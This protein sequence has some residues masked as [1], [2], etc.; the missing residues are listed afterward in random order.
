MNPSTEGFTSFKELDRRWA[1]IKGSAFRAFKR[2][3]PGLQEGRDFLRLDA[4]ADRDAIQRLRRAGRIYN[5]SVHV[6]L[7]SDSGLQ[8]LTR[9]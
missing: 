2:A 3:L 6:V 5:G 7:L 9:P 4:V 8:K 1:A